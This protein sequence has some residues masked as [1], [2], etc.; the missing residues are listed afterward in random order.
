MENFRIDFTLSNP[1]PDG[2]KIGEAGEKN[3]AQLII[4]PPENL[5]S[6]EEIKSYVVAFSTEK[7]PVRIGP[8]PKAETLTVPVRNALTVGTAL[9]VQIEGYD[10]DGEFIIKSPVLSGI[11]ISNSI[12]ECGCSDGSCGDK[13]V[14]PGHM[15]ENLA[16]LD[17]LSEENGVLM[18]NGKEVS[19]SGEVKTV[20]LNSS[21]GSF[22]AFCDVP[23]DQSFTIFSNTDNEGNSYIPVGAEIVSVELNIASPDEPEWV[24]LRDMNSSESFVPYFIN[25]Y[26]AF[27]SETLCG[28][29]IATA[30]FMNTENIY[31]NAISSYALYGVRV[32]Y[33]DSSGETE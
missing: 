26:K 31:Y 7:G 8:F 9:S 22:C 5:A 3:A 28:T 16:V 13:N 11:T 18:F 25:S 21:D 2:K 10:A 29:V 6:R 15:H 30:Y 19:S 1:F 24:D 14:L 20:V 23:V 4:P 33:I 17:S 32:R 12:G 27:Y